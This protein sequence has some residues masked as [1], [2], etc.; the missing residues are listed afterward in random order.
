M[1]GNKRNALIVGETPEFVRWSIRQSCPLREQSTLDSA[2]QTWRQLRAIQEIGLAFA[3]S[4]VHDGLALKGFP[5][6]SGTEWC[7]VTVDEVFATVGGQEFVTSQCT[8]CPANAARRLA[9]CFGMVLASE[10]SFL[11]LKEWKSTWSQENWD[12]EGKAKATFAKLQSKTGNHPP[13]DSLKSFLAACESV[14]EHSLRLDVQ[15]F[16]AGF[17]DGL[18]WTIHSHCPQC[19]TL[20]PEQEKSCKHCGRVG[21]AIRTQKRKVVGRRPFLSLVQLL[22][23]SRASEIE[24]WCNEDLKRS[25]GQNDETQTQ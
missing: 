14:I 20:Q 15:L 6:D 7:G 23:S 16:P 5:T 4:R 17:S 13:C 8:N 2:E 25:R 1:S 24:T 10:W 12:T 18:T 22:G 9:G 21:S 11:S 3:E 19:K